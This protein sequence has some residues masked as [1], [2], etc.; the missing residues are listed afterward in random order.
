MPKEVN[1]VLKY[2]HAYKSMK[3]PFV[4]FAEMQS[5]LEEMSDCHNSPKK[6]STSKI[7]KI[8][9][10]VMYYLDIV[11]LMLQKIILIIIGLK[12]V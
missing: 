8:H 11:H 5:L 1:N 12:T 4:I 9:L 10:L 2:N 7:N 6:S 3:V